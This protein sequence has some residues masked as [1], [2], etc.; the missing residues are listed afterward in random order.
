ML[1]RV[2]LLFILISSFSILFGQQKDRKSENQYLIRWDKPGKINI[3]E[4]RSKNYLR[5]D[6]SIYADSSDLPYYFTL[7]DAIKSSMVP[8][9]SLLNPV[10]EELPSADAEIIDK[11][12]NMLPEHII[13][14]TKVSYQNKKPLMMVSFLPLRRNPVNGRAERLVSFSFDYSYSTT[15]I[16]PSV[17]KAYQYASHSVLSS[18]DWYRV[19]VFRSGI[20]IITYNDL[21]SLGINVSDIDPKNIRVYGN[22]GSMLPEDNSKF[23]FDDLVENAIFVYGEGDGIFDQNDYIL[24]YAKGPEKWSF[25]TVNNVYNHEINKYVKR[26]GYFITASLGPGKRVSTIT[27]SSQPADYSVT[28][29]D[30]YLFHENDSLNLIKSGREFYGE[31]F[32]VNTSYSFNFNFPNLV[33]GVPV[34]FKGRFLARSFVYP[35][36][37]K[38]YANN[39]F[40]NSVSVLPASPDYTAAYARDSQLFCSFSASSPVNIR[41]DYNKSSNSSAVGWLDYI[42]LNTQRYLTFVPGQMSFRNYNSVGK[43]ISE[44]IM[45]NAAGDVVVW[46]VTDYT[47]VKKVASTL[48]GSNLSF[49]LNTDSLR[50]FV[51]FNGAD[52]YSV[53]C[54]GRIQN[55]DLHGLGQYDMIIISHPDLTGEASRIAD[56]HRNNDNLTVLITT[57]QPIYN[58]FSSGNQDITAI[59]DFVKMFYD[60]AGSDINL[61]PKFLLLFGD[62]SYDYQNRLSGNTNMVPTY[63][64]QNSLE[65]SSSYLTDDYFGFLDD[66]DNGAYNNLLDIAIGRIPAQNV[67][68]AKAVTDKI[69]NY[70]AKYDLNA[71]N[72]SCS[73]FSDAISNFSDWRN[74]LCFVADDADTPGEDF[75]GQSESIAS[76]LDTVY[77]NFNL[78]KIY[79]D[80]YTQVSTPGGQR[81][82]DATDAINRRVA[83]G[84]LI[85]NYIGH[86]GEVGWAH[87]AVIGVA[88]INSW[89]NKNNM[90]LFVT[91]TCEFSRFDDPARTSAGEYVLLNPVGG[92]IS[93]FTTTRLAFAGT[94]YSLNFAFYKEVFKKTSG[95]YPYLG[96]VTKAAKNQLGCSYVISNFVLLGDPALRLAYPEH[97]II[98][99]MLNDQPLGGLTDTVRALEKIAIKGYVADY[100]GVKLTNYQGTIMPVVFDKAAKVVSNGNDGGYPQTFSLQKNII[101]KGKAKVVNGDFR[102]TFVVP[103]DIAY[104]FGK[105]RISYYAQN[106]VSDANGFYENFIIGGT[107]HNAITDNSG[108]ELKVYM[109]DNHFVSGGITDRNPLL[110]AYLSDSGGVNTIGNSIGHDISAVLD[111]NTDKTFVLNDY[112]ESDLDTYQSGVVRYPFSDLEPGEHK[113]LLKAWDVY[114]NSAETELDF[115][116]AESAELALDHVF[117]YPNP[118]TTYTEFWFEHNQPCCGL[119]VQIQIFTVT[120]KL[121]KT[122]QTTVETSG[123]RADPIP[124]DGKDDFGDSIGKGVYLY[125]LKVKNS[126]GQYC[127]KT[128]KLVILK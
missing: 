86:G 94:N 65:P 41:V 120:G 66:D 67:D 60:R 85:V 70:V 14:N 111:G 10:Y 84:A 17:N 35:T 46:D 112:Y 27:S 12:L 11:Q 127:Q 126:S 6:G 13:I 128:E 18:G 103:K 38:I 30:D 61:Q 24:F 7:L 122:I 107:S 3:S 2:I 87:E 36:S 20:H 102:F 88:D 117:N 116:V 47:D 52:F 63:Q 42:E 105:G 119:D 55:Q 4:L 125:I 56:M 15:K 108:P 118:F 45:G 54:S 29:F 99:T 75:L 5:F 21:V 82:P 44:F 76:Y 91:A 23:R 104:Q 50:E 106:G 40:V 78:D 32:D 114:N 115:V 59:K 77:N 48:N 89:N 64:T 69:L 73:G 43:G 71:G 123:F 95:H 110:I 93:L 113:L 22:G 49:K 28:T 83:K 58:E 37:Y 62:A 96:N 9:I 16:L 31:V 72:S 90:P 33:S 97:N 26:S 100:N 57:P 74:V 53:S 80:A 121:I 39:S 92:G 51:A 1:R 68:E 109:N 124:W 101:Y 25:D 34:Y 19:D 81:Y 8:D 79:M 98:T